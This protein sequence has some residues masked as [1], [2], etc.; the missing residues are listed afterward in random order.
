MALKKSS[1]PFRLHLRGNHMNQTQK[2][3]KTEK[4]IVNGE[5]LWQTLIDIAAFGSI[6]GDGSC[7]LSL[8]DEDKEA[9]D[10]FARWCEEAGLVRTVDRYGNMFAVREGRDKEAPCILIGSHLD[11][12]PH[13]GRFDGVLGVLADLEL[14]RSFNDAG[15]ETESPIAIV[16]WTNEEG[17]RFK[18]GLTGSAGFAGTLDEKAVSGIDGTDFFGELRRIGYAGD[19]KFDRKIGAYYELHIEQG[20]VLERAGLPVGIVNGIQGVRWYEVLIDGQDSHAGTTPIQDR[21]DSFMAAAALAMKLRFEALSLDPNLRFTIGRVELSPNSTNTVPGHA[22]LMIDLR[23]GD[24]NLLDA[25]EIKMAAATSQ[26]DQR[27]GVKTSAKRG[28]RRLN[29]YSTY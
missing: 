4:A 1:G 17:V 2:V 22:K 25:F 7:R 28:W 20:P 19:A 11:T 13:G 18:P 8:T 3:R 21:H 27:E 6:P 14:L 5:R 26:I 10:L 12:Q 29:G 15:I 23:H 24:S 9:R 16:N